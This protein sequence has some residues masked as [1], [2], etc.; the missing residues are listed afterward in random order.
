M[1]SVAT[2]DA[3]PVRGIVAAEA[4]QAKTKEARMTSFMMEK[5]DEEQ[6]VQSRRP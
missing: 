3:N 1:S 6:R 5:E 2:G 4:I